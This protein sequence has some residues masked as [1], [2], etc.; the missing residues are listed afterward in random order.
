MYTFEPITSFDKIGSFM[1][2]RIRCRATPTHLYVINPHSPGPRSANAQRS[3]VL[4]AWFILCICA[5]SKDPS[6]AT[7][8]QV[9]SCSGL[10]GDSRRWILTCYLCH[11]LCLVIRSFYSGVH[12]LHCTKAV[13]W[14]CRKRLFCLCPFVPELIAQG[15]G[16]TK[17]CLKSISPYHGNM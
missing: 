11:L 5:A 12:W 10:L 15:T 13:W 16:K 17:S 14:R 7:L 1:D 8:M 3:G 4:C 2:F 9:D 6:H